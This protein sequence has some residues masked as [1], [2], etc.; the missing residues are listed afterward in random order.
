MNVA[1]T[2]KQTLY[3]PVSPTDVSTSAG[4]RLYDTHICIQARGALNKSSDKVARRPLLFSAKACAL[5][6]SPQPG[7]QGASS[8]VPGEPSQV[9]ATLFAMDVKTPIFVTVCV[10]GH[11]RARLG[12]MYKKQWRGCMYGRFAQIQH[13]N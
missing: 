3:Q 6:T 12:I 13:A 10:C 7:S 11:T 1:R 8:P 2:K 4:L 5:H 9:G